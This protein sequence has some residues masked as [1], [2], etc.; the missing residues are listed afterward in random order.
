MIHSDRGKHSP[1]C[2]WKKK[3]KLSWPS[4][5]NTN[6]QANTLLLIYLVA[7]VTTP[8]ESSISMLVI[9]TSTLLC[10]TNA[11]LAYFHY[12][13]S[14]SMCVVLCQTKFAYTAQVRYVVGRRAKKLGRFSSRIKSPHSSMAARQVAVRRSAAI[15]LTSYEWERERAWKR[16]Q[17]HRHS[18]SKETDDVLKIRR[19]PFHRVITRS[20]IVQYVFVQF[21]WRSSSGNVINSS[22]DTERVFLCV[23]PFPFMRTFF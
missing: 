22:Y 12:T 2:L 20:F 6:K 21:G 1:S 18:H 16:R 13:C 23:S 8:N 17:Y 4:N 10:V 14:V 3:I 5:S 19:E 15:I 11:F 7:K 9:R